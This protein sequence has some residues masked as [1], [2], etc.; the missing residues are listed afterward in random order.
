MR[1]A[2]RDLSLPF[3]PRIYA[4]PPE[5]RSTASGKTDFAGLK[6]DWLSGACEVLE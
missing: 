2:R 4:K 1:Y 3:V 5:W 6:A